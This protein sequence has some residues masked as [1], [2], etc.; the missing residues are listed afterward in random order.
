M[1]RAV[2]GALCPALLGAVV[3]SSAREKRQEVEAVPHLVPT[4]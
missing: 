4:G 2:R 3:I 1:V